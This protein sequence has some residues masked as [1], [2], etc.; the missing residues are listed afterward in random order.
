MATAARKARVA[1]LEAVHDTQTLTQTQKFAGTILLAKLG[2][3]ITLV[4]RSNV[5]VYKVQRLFWW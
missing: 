2:Y 1:G 3:S 5:E 4:N